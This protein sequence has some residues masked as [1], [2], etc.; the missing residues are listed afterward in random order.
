ME[1][2]PEQAREVARLRRQWPQAEVV[3]HHRE[4]DLILEVRRAGHTV[5]LRRFGDDGSVV[6]PGALAA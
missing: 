4:H 5:T 6:T 3:L 2:T 1:L